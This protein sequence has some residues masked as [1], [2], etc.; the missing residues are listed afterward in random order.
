MEYIH[1]RSA[2]D[3]L[4]QEQVVVFEGFRFEIKDDEGHTV[5]NLDVEAKKDDDALA[6]LRE[7]DDL[8]I[9]MNAEGRELKA[10]RVLIDEATGERILASGAELEG[11][12]HQSGVPFRDW[13]GTAPDFYADAAMDSKAQ[14]YAPASFTATL[15]A[16]E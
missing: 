7:A 8:N 11:E 9:F 14:G 3:H 16:A 1:T 13:K 6:L 4:T 5:W 15:I 10:A 12:P 2:L